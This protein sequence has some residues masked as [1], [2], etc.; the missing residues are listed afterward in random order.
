M[1]AMFQRELLF[2]TGKGGVGKKTVALALALAAGR[3]GRRVALCEVAGQA[4]APRLYGVAAGAAG[5]ERGLTECVWATTLD[6]LRALE[7]WAGHVVGSRRL[8][9][10]LA[11]SNAF[12]A[13]VA[14]APGAREL[15]AMTKAWELGRRERWTSGARRYDLV[16]VDGPATGHGVGLLRTPRTFAD[17][18]RVGPIAT[19]SRRVAELLEDPERAAIVAV[20]QPAEMPVS[21]ALDLEERV[22]LALG[23]ALDVVVL[24]AVR[25]RRFSRDEV[26]R[27]VAA[28]DRV[29]SGA[30]DAVCR[31]HGVGGE[32][33][34]QLRRLRREAAAPVVTLPFVAS[35]A[36]GP[37]E[38]E[39]LS[40][41]LERRLAG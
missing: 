38:V 36:L 35:P 6:P 23:R 8:V 31:G 24:N 27:I 9:H 13:F 10:V 15:L 1:N 40:E 19:Q 21:E 29:P 2:V 16:V 11:R 37:D 3:E 17:I 7:E 5:S 4:H 33:Q 32:Q 39:Q 20:A 34:R 30:R 25:P 18:A 22:G 28:G 41:V 12:H 26:D 14:A